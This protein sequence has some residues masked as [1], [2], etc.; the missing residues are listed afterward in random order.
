MIAENDIHDDMPT[1]NVCE[2]QHR[3]ERFCDRLSHA[4]M[5]SD[6][7]GLVTY[8]NDPTSEYLASSYLGLIDVYPKRRTASG[9]TWQVST[10]SQVIGLSYSG[11]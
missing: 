2:P 5:A 9:P 3:A 6:S 8:V 4:T 1:P 7:E 11:V 10:I